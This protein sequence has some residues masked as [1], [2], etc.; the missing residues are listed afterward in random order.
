L[1]DPQKTFRLK[2]DYLAPRNEIEEKIL[3]CWQKVLNISQIGINDNFFELGGH[4]LKG[5]RLLSL[6]NQAFQIELPLRT[7]F[8]ATTIA[9]LA[10]MIIEKKLEQVGNDQG[11]ALLAE[12]KNLSSDEVKMHLE[13][14][15]KK[16]PVGETRE[17]S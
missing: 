13:Q 16:H 11:T 3:E 12:I 17:I 7:L 15:Q 2:T 5:M 4:S 1:P 6:L 10:L 8:E 9:S 14:T